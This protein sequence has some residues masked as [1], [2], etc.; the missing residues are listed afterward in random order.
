MEMVKISY[1]GWP[2]CIRIDNGTV[3][4][5]ATTDVG[6]R[7][8]RYGH[9]GGQNVFKEYA[10]Q[11]GKTG[12][13]AWRIYGG[14]RFWHAPEVT[15]RT[16][17]PDNG[18]VEHDWD[19]TRLRLANQEPGNGIRKEIEV[20]LAASG[21]RVDLLHRLVNL[22]PWDIE[23]APWSL[24]VMAQGGREILPQ[25]PFRAHD[26]YLL[27]ARPLVLWHYTDMSDPR[28]RFGKKYVTLRQDPTATTKQK[29]GLLNRQAWMAYARDGEVFV[30]RH[31]LPGDG[32]FPDFGCNEETYTDADMLEMETL[33]PLTRLA[34]NGGT[35]EHL[36]RW[37]LF[38]AELGD[39]EAALDAALL[40]LVEQ[41][42]VPGS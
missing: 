30:K 25:E 23:L 24:S 38:K 42:G 13:D 2:N 10:D 31:G 36:E 39:D 27:P 29:L 28:W 19:G 6:P 41:V 33:G 16:Y 40:P 37:S 8:I 15:P 12:G 4:L 32:A 26:E 34:A 14:H 17:W 20:R 35:V 5:V 1:G 9:A 22:G 11:I 3:E 18:P 7:V 21:S